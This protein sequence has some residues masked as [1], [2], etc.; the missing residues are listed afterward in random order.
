[1]TADPTPT[2]TSSGPKPEHTGGRGRARDLGTWVVGAI[3]IGIALTWFAALFLH[4]RQGTMMVPLLWEIYLITL[5]LPIALLADRVRPLL[6][7]P[8]LVSRLPPL[9]TPILLL[10]TVLMLFLTPRRPEIHDTAPVAV[11]VL[12]LPD[13]ATS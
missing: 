4:F 12:P 3:A 13:G 8:M 7:L 6:L 10:G 5:I 1:V 2:R 9:F 11:R